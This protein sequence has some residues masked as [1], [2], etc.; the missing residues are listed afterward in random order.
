MKQSCNE[1][2]MLDFIR[3]VHYSEAYYLPAR[4]AIK[5]HFPELF[6]IPKEKVKKRFV[7]K[8]K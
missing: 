8:Q 4:E 2:L 6:Q 3:D 7:R 1:P 5:K